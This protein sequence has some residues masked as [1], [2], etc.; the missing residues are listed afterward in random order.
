MK[1]LFATLFAS[2]V[3]M[4]GSAQS[5]PI[6]GSWIMLT[7]DGSGPQPF[8][9]NFCPDGRVFGISFSQEFKTQYPWYIGSYKM[10]DDS[11]YVEHITYHSNVTF[12]HD[13]QFVYKRE[14][15]S[16]LITTYNNRFANAID[17]PVVEGWKKVDFPVKDYADHLDDIKQQALT[18]YN[19]VPKPGVTVEQ[20]GEELYKNY[21]KF[22][23]ENNLEAANEVL[24][25]RAE[26]DTTN[27]QWQADVL[28]FYLEIK[29]LP[30]ITD[31]IAER[32]VRLA[33]Q[34]APTP[35][36]TSVVNA[37]RIRGGLY[38]NAS[39]V[40][41]AFGDKA[42]SDIN[43]ALELQKASGR[44]FTKDDGVSY[45]LLAYSYLP[46][47]QWDQVL[48]NCEKAID[49]FEKA[50]NVTNQQKGEGYFLKALTLSS[51]NKKKEAIDVLLHKTAPLFIDEQGKPM[52][53]I[54]SEVYPYAFYAYGELICQ[55][56]QDK[57][58]AKEYQ[59]F[60]ADK[61]PC[62]VTD[63]QNA[64]LPKGEYYI[65]EMGSWTIDEVKCLEMHNN[66]YVMQKDGNFL[67]I[68]LGDDEK[69][70]GQVIVKTVDPSYKQ[71]IIKL[72]KK[73][74]KNK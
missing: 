33:E 38:G 73:Y 6:E 54:E 2:L 32:Y 24:L 61:V 22:K 66:H 7:N 8:I 36:D 45:M 29:G 47:E 51:M 46:L 15:D 10:L 23:G 72:W 41:S 48:E 60:M 1:K 17:V 35:T 3:A 43:K 58:L 52:P 55:N 68:D 37:Y 39:H 44:P 40:Q 42:R 13:I 21:E 74:K 31:K 20:Y 9:K 25:V 64:K 27:V 71:Q 11:T 70:G 62:G 30:A 5:S 50:P 59:Q 63:G 65:M 34:Q 69:L 19:R 49:I 56:P 67:E 28:Q 57:Q 4:A 16:I 18:M 53:K 14:N 12:Q 26:L